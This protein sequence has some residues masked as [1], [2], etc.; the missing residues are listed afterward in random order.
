M[1]EL[2]KFI[3]FIE[4]LIEKEEK[5]LNHL[6]QIKDESNKIDEFI[7]NSKKMLSHYKIR[8]QEYKEACQI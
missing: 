6:K 4:K 3:P 2:E 7:Q 1:K 8:L 5:H